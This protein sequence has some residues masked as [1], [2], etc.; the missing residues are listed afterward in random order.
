VVRFQS[1]QLWEL[2]R[3]MC[4]YARTDFSC[5]DW[6]WGNMKQRCPRQPRMGETCG[7]KLPDLDNITTVA[8]PCRV[9]VEKAVK[10]RRLARE[11]DNIKRWKQEGNRFSA[12]IER[13]EREVH[14]LKQTIAE[15]ERKRTSVQWGGNLPQPNFPNLTRMPGPSSKR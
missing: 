3:N 5:K 15:L 4:Y 14:Q 12:S 1:A 9:C 10:E 11:E 2:V 7:A 6:R 8:E 13:A